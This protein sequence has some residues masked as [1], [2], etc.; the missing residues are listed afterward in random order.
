VAH[1]RHSDVDRGVARVGFGILSSGS[2]ARALQGLRHRHSGLAY[3]LGLRH[4][5]DADHISAIDNTTR[6]LLM[7]DTGRGSERP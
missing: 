5:F 3:T 6:K 2:S 7:N 1:H 4:A